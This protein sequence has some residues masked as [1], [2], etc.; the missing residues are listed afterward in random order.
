MFWPIIIWTFILQF[1]SANHQSKDIQTP[2]MQSS[3]L[4]HCGSSKTA[5]ISLAAALAWITFAI[6]IIG[7]YLAMNNSIEWSASREIQK[8]HEPQE[9]ARLLPGPLKPEAVAESVPRPRLPRDSANTVQTHQMGKRTARNHPIR[10]DPPKEHPPQTHP[11]R[12]NTEK[13][14]P[15]H[16]AE[17]TREID[18]GQSGEEISTEDHSRQSRSKWSAAKLSREFTRGDTNSIG[19]GEGDDSEFLN[20]QG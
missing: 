19:P 6:I 12:H 17:D 10:T 20:S 18:S 11:R 4:D 15:R 9:K 14:K 2:K 8:P 16:L 7:T 5:V 13:S 3:Q 1:C